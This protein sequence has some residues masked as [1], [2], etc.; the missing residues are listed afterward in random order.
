MLFAEYWAEVHTGS[1][2]SPLA[3][4]SVLGNG[5][6]RLLIR[7]GR[8]KLKNKLTMPLGAILG[9]F[10]LTLGL[11]AHANV[12]NVGPDSASV[13]C[14]AGTVDPACEGV[15]GN[16]GSA[17][18]SATDATLYHVR[19][20]DEET[21]TGFLN[22]LLGLTLDPDD[23]TRIDTGGASSASFSTTA[24][25]FA[26]K[27]GNRTA[28]FA[29]NGGEIE[30]SVLYESIAGEGAGIS[31]VTF[32]GGTTTQVSEPGT[33]ALLGMG[34]MGFGLMRRKRAA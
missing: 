30:L 17:E 24:T 12:I 19:P 26:I 18:L 27:A 21:E 23:A 34:I 6:E 9:V 13:N 33:L 20:S 22:S 16:P 7:L 1:M 14:T 10:L 5:P 8:M 15:V 2:V 28:F 29:N 3:Q 32:W 31:H 4:P 11:S 25:W